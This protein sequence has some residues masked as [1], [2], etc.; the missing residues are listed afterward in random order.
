M[1]NSI[2]QSYKKIKDLKVYENRWTKK[3]IELHMAK[4]AISRNLIL[5]PLIFYSS[6][7]LKHP[8]WKYKYS[9]D[10]SINKNA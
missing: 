6:I 9:Y 5:F 10:W 7:W 2:N 1:W 3:C 8:C 4:K